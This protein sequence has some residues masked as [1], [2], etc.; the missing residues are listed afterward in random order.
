ML[1]AVAL[2]FESGSDH[3]DLDPVEL[4]QGAPRRLQA[5]GG[6]PVVVGQ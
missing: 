1:R 3:V 4:A 2:R 5:G 6:D